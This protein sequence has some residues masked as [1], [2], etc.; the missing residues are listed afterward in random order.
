M[1]LSSLLGHTREALQL[2]R[3][4][5]K[6]ADTLIESFFRTRKYLGSHDRRFIAET[7]YGTLRHL[8]RCEAV[9]LEA[10]GAHADGILPEDG[11][12]LL[13]T[14]YL[15]VVEHDARLS[16][17]EVADAVKSG[18][19]KP[20]IPALLKAIREV[21]EPA[22]E[23]IVE[24]IGLRHSF[25]DWMVQR[26]VGQY[27]EA[28]AEQI[29][30]SLNSQAPITLRVNTLRT[31]V[32]EC[33]HQ[34]AEEGVGTEPCRLSPFGLHVSKRMNVFSLQSFRNG[35]FEVQD[36]GSQL[37]PLLLDPKPTAKVLDAC[38]GAGG[39]TLGLSALMK[40]RGE[41]VATDVHDTRLEEL[42]RRLRRAGASNVRVRHVEDV[43]ELHDKFSGYFDI[44]L[45][46]APCSG[47]GTLRRNP[48]MKWM[49][50][51]ETV[52][53]V[54]QKQRHI[55]EASSGLI[56][57]GGLLGYATCTL[58]REE[59]ED[60]V[61]AFLR[62]H[63]EFKPERPPIDPSRLDASPFFADGYVKFYPHRDGTDGF[64]IS[65]LKRHSGGTD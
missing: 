27:G 43:A 20:R 8:R 56:K 54:S 28:E 21:P 65:I 10:M 18:T 60:V 22:S 64:F 62:A 24:R 16:D 7:A 59:N 47:L 48:G 57:V 55:L 9:L 3:E 17:S 11:F 4:S 15:I 25:P 38:A 37:L 44:V 53:E 61:D 63:P 41:I 1:K 45:V 29:C 14:T 35:L 5:G 49:V 12:L 39:K 30:E 58:L 19:L 13:V 42:R 2:V 6:P 36:E 34:L 40:N 32:E 23:S 31:T 52:K 26:F 50:T 51:E 46:D 33:R